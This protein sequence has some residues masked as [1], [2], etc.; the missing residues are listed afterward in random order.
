MVNNGL[1]KFSSHTADNLTEFSKIIAR[2]V[3]NELTARFNIDLPAEA[4][5]VIVKVIADNLNIKRSLDRENVS[6]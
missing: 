6:R 2:D 4:Y 5:P 1:G 3:I